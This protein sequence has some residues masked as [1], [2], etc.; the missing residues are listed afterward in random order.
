[1]HARW[2]GYVA[3][4][5]PLLWFFGGVLW[6]GDVLDFRDISH[7]Y[8]PV[9]HWTSSEWSQGRVPLWC[10]LDGLGMPIHADPTATI[11]Y[12]GQLLL[13]LP[14]DFT[15][16]LNLYLVAHLLLAAVLLYRTARTWQATR[17]GAVAGALCYAYGGHVLFQYCNPI[18]LVGAAWLPLVVLATERTYHLRSWRWAVA[19]AAAL[20]M[21]I[22]GGDPQSAYHALLLAGLLV[23]LM[24]P[25]DENSAQAT[26]RPVVARAT[27]LLLLG[28]AFALAGAL[29]AVQLLPT[30]EWS[31]RSERAIVDAPRSLWELSRDSRLAIGLLQDPPRHS[32]HE[33]IY[34]FS[35]APWR[36]LEFVW[37]N[38]AGRMFPIHQ[39]WM[40]ALPAEGRVW[41]PS[42]YLGLIPLVSALAVFSL[43]RK[44]DPRMRWC[45]WMVVIGLL[46][47]L[48]AYG[49]GWLWE[50]IRCGWLG[51]DAA[52]KSVF[53][54]VGGLY[55][56]L[57]TVLPSY[58][59]F[60]YPAKLMLLTSLGVALL[61]ARGWDRLFSSEQTVPR[62]R[63][64]IGWSVLALGS[65]TAMVAIRSA[66]PWLE[67]APA[68]FPFGALDVSG[69]ISDVTRSALHALTVATCLAGLVWLRNRLSGRIAMAAAVAITVI[70]LSCA[71]GW[72]ISASPPLAIA[73]PQTQ[74]V[75]SSSLTR[76]RIYRQR[77]PRDFH[78]QP[79]DASVH[80]LTELGRWE[81]ATLAEKTA[82]EQGQNLANMTNALEPADLAAVWRQVN[83]EP[84]PTV[85]LQ[86]FGVDSA[87]TPAA[88][89]LSPET[90]QRHLLSTQ[91]PAYFANIIKI[92][93]PSKVPRQVRL[94]PIPPTIVS[95]LQARGLDQRLALVNDSAPIK[96]V[97][98]ISAHDEADTLSL[99]RPRPAEVIVRTQTASSRFLV[100]ADY[101]APGWICEITN[102]A[103]G[104]RQRAPIY[105]TNGVL[106]GVV[107]PA[108]EHVVT[109]RYRPVR[110]YVGTVIS[111]IAWLGVL[112]V[113]GIH[114]RECR[115]SR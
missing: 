90:T 47:S 79:L 73:P 59:Q 17:A 31:A 105:R 114:L 3:M 16:R 100:L 14:L 112:V 38:I 49:I 40:S 108:G 37:P 13:V 97:G 93:Q 9:W 74:S 81:R 102:E 43:R 67:A 23:W 103:T 115:R 60:R 89:L 22:L 87:L 28:G 70:D 50:E 42:L 69:A 6:R 91:P 30:F 53:G 29:A 41:S 98:V 76:S 8:R 35:V 63:V 78:E 1:M 82:L 21:L 36:W 64:L 71:H 84:D 10:D 110:L 58:V 5:T 34:D 101:D 56:W 46:G 33:R 61:A 65:I 62:R 85:A 4:I 80:R 7:Y 86:M 106:R 113:A 27:P 52:D 44:A 75:D 19:L 72:L 77:L 48:G 99:S 39:R 95:S 96:A 83:R 57:V 18:Y 92:T 55:W 94:H 20:A 26:P 24:R 32:H 66:Q 54:A 51:G 104:A 25:R 109:F 2:F 12:P 88:E 15:T 11:F 68:E 107:V 45:A 111:A